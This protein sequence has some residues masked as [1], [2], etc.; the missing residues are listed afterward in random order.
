MD[1]SNALG[2]TFQ[3]VRDTEHNGQ[4][5]RSVTGS[6]IYPTDLDDMWDALTNEE[7]LPRWFMP[8]SGDLRVG[9][10]YQLKGNAEGTITRCD[11][12]K[13]L[14]VTWEFGGNVSWVSVCLG[15]EESGVRLDLVH[16]MLKD[17]ASEAHWATYGP[18][19]TGV[20]WD[21]GFSGLGLHLANGG[22]KIDNE[23]L[24]AWMATDAGKAFVHACAAA[25]GNAHIEA[26]ED[27]AVAL[28]MADKTAS[29]YTGV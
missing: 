26:G 12:P 11:P 9:G 3:A 25:W 28:A 29:F 20:G 16:T 13:M 22:A 23:A 27:E 24:F 1:F 18:G 14:E 4:P 10:R 15:K 21:L 7:R 8:V 5:A 19:A 17:E 6:R 2:T